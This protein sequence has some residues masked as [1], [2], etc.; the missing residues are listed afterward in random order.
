MRPERAPRRWLR[1]LAFA[2]AFLLLW[3]GFGWNALG[4]VSAQT[5]AASQR[6]TEGLVF[7]RLAAAE[8]DGFFTRGALLGFAGDR[9]EDLVTYDSDVLWR[10]YAPLAQRW[11]YVEGSPFRSFGA[12]FTHNGFQGS[13]FV[14]L[15]RALAFLPRARRVAVFVALTAALTAAL[16]AALAC[17]LARELGL[18]AGLFALAAA[19]A[20]PWLT[21]LGPNLYF[22]LWLYGLPA[23]TV[24]L[25]LARATPAN[26]TRRLAWAAF[27]GFLPRHLA[28]PEFLTATAALAVAPIAYLALRERTGGRAFLRRTL[29]AGTASAAGLVL[30]LGLLALQIRA[31]TG[32]FDSVREHLELSWARRAGDDPTGLSAAYASAIQTEL[33][34]VLR[35][36]LDDPLDREAAGAP[37]ALAWIRARSHGELALLTLAAAAWLALRARRLAPATRDRVLGLFAATFCAFLGVLAWLIVFK[38]HAALH[39][40]QIPLMWHLGFVPLAAALVGWALGDGLCAAARVLYPARIPRP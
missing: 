26:E 10:S 36:Y 18:G 25:A 9:R 32:S 21:S 31:V 16:F 27:L 37:G 15:D 23:F 4:A 11:L 20:S 5:F 17:A 38:S 7:G 29:V 35:Y 30:A 3:A 2:G 1:F 6:D 19:G 40:H 8:R 22:S 24:A 33:G 12:Y 34:T 13:V 39:P 28:G 14:L